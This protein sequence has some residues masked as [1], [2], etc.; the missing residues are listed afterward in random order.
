MNE[1][2]NVAIRR[3]HL[4]GFAI[5]G[6]AAAAASAIG[7]EWAR[8]KSE[9]AS[10]KRKARYQPNSPVVRNFYRVNSYPRP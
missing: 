10:D 7:S 4:L 5:A 1:Q 8:G 2:L 9:D 6:V 3:R